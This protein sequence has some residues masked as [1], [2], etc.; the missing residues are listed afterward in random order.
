[1]SCDQPVVVEAVVRRLEHHHRADVHRRRRL[2]QVEEGRVEGRQAV[3]HPSIVSDERVGTGLTYTGAHAPTARQ[4]DLRPAGP[5]RDGAQ[6]PR[7]VQQPVPVRHRGRAGRRHQSGLRCSRRQR[8]HQRHERGQRLRVRLGRASL[9]R[10][11]SAASAT[12]T[13]TAR[14][15]VITVTGQAGAA[16]T[17]HGGPARRADAHPDGHQ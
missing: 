2:L 4:V 7:R 12:A 11:S 15:L 1:M 13:P 8:R 16:R 6:R 5:R 14:A 9:R 10:A 17:D 3:G